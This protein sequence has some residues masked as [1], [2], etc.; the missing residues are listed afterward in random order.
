MENNMHPKLNLMNCS[1]RSNGMSGNSD[2]VNKEVISDTV[3]SQ[4][5]PCLCAQKCTIQYDIFFFSVSFHFMCS[6]LSIRVFGHC[7]RPITSSHLMTS[8]S[9]FLLYG[10]GIVL[11]VLWVMLM[12]VWV[13]VTFIWTVPIVSVIILIWLVTAV[14]VSIVVVWW[15][16]VTPSFCLV[17]IYFHVL[18]IQEDLSVVDSFISHVWLLVTNTQK[19][20]ISCWSESQMYDQA[21]NTAC[22]NW[23]S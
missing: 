12:I 1:L 18:I 15:R 23:Y 10:V 19:N 13:V 6:V 3:S 4:N 5:F 21:L 11:A 7:S 20:I 22:L 8:V 9:C 2:Q 17:W 14:V 16:P